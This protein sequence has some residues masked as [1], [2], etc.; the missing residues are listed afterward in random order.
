MRRTTKLILL[1]CLM[2]CH[3]A[4]YD[5]EVDGVYYTV[6]DKRHRMVE[7][8]HWEEQTNEWGMPQRVCHHHDCG[9]GGHQANGHLTHR[10]LKLIQMDEDARQRER[11]A[12]Q[13]NV[14]IP[15]TVRYKG[16]TY[17]V[18]GVGDGSFYG[19]KQMTGIE[20]PPTV[21][22]IGRSAF[23]QCTALKTV[24]LP[25]AVTRIGFAAFRR[26]TSL[27]SLT[28]SDSLRTIDIYAFAFCEQ[29]P[30]IEIP[31]SVDSI[32]G[33]VIFASDNL[34]SIILPHSTPPVIRDD[35]GLTMDFRKIVF[36]V[37][38]Q[39]L[40]LYRADAFWQKQKVRA[41]H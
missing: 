33:N 19:R 14:V 32:H 15:Q 13:G 16:R 39:Y 40:P 24:C 34:K 3:C 17:T 4:A 6:T 37:P 2:A 9:C 12:Y 31:A 36:Y 21:T 8:S 20:L 29:L 10:H 27:T 30:Q 5:F 28:L 11:T 7:V 22:Y 18:T 25:A 38:E 35:V 23:G 41:A 1:L 26:C